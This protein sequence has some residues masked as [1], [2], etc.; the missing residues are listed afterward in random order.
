[1]LPE[2][3]VE[4]VVR[5]DEVEHPYRIRRENLPGAPFFRAEQIGDQLVVF[6]NTSH[7]FF[8]HVYAGPRST[9]AT[10]AGLELLLFV[11]GECW[12][13]ASSDA[14]SYYKAEVPEWSRR[15]EIAVDKLA[16]LKDPGE[17]DLPAAAEAA[18]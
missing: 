15:L 14:K 5:K 13:D 8:T 17:D 18:D 3:Q 4:E 1:M 11:I 12:Q 6:L 10:R 7:G 16:E 2:A 9:P